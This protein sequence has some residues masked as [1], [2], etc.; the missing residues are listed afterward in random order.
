[1]LGGKYLYQPFILVELCSCILSFFFFFSGQQRVADGGDTWAKRKNM[2]CQRVEILAFVFITIF[3]SQYPHFGD[4]VGC[5]AA[6][7]FQDL[8]LFVC[9]AIRD[10]RYSWAGVLG[11]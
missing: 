4:G 9:C 1:M 8:S 3:Y 5:W 6:T 10:L 2:C 7:R 11:L